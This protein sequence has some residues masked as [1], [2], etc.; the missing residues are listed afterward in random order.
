MEVNRFEMLQKFMQ[1]FQVLVES[2][3]LDEMKRTKMKREAVIKSAHNLIE[4]KAM[5]WYKL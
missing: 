4:I 5:K 2:L 3:I 1:L